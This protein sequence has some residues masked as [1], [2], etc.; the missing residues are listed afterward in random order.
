[1]SRVHQTSMSYHAE[2]SNV[3]HVLNSGKV[4][5]HRGYISV[6]CDQGFSLIRLFPDFSV[7][8]LSRPSVLHHQALDVKVSQPATTVILVNIIYMLLLCAMRECVH[9]FKAK[10]STPRCGGYIRFYID[11][12]PC[13]STFNSAGRSRSCF[14][15]IST[16][17]SLKF[18]LMCIWLFR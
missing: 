18:G 15:W 8:V 10:H 5:V 13:G 3:P 11:H 17:A 6:P 14:Y 4:R 9:L 2:V 7:S 16:P 12:H 1:M